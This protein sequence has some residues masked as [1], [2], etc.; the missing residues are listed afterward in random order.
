[1]FEQG[2]CNKAAAGTLDNNFDT[3]ILV[4]CHMKN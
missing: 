1:M 3:N 2:P 4:G